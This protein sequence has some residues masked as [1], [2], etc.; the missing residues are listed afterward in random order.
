[1]AETLGRANSA[2]RGEDAA[3]QR[4]PRERAPTAV[5]AA[6]RRRSRCSNLACLAPAPSTRGSD[7]T[8]RLVRLGEARWKRIV[9]V[10]APY[11]WN[12]RRLLGDRDVLEVGCGIGRNLAHLA[13]RAVGVDHNEA[14][15]E[16]CRERGLTAF[17]TAEFA[18]T[19]YARPGRFG[20]LL[21]AHLV[22]HMMHAEAIATL[23]GYLHYLRDDARAVL[24][25]PQERGFASD[26]THVEF[27]DF[28][29]LADVCRALGMAERRRISFPLPRSAGRVFTH[30]E[31]VLVSE[32][33]LTGR[34]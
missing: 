9:G 25:C 34:P 4:R 19:E 10:Q 12:V 11:R 1:M 20:G 2:S 31:F 5:S 8:D 23:A 32:R 16:A 15:I 14:S 7:Y 3:H 24:I 33:Q 18:A 22:E 29:A 28:D 27:A 21:A 30:N 6:R 17:T 13:P 26:A